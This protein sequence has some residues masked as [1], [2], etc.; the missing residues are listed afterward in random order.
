MKTVILISILAFIFGSAYSQ[1]GSQNQTIAVEFKVLGE[2]GMCKTR[3]EKAAKLE[4]VTSAV[5]DQ[6]TK[7]LKVKYR[8]SIVKVEAI[9]KSIAKAGHDTEKE[10]ADDA[11][12]NKLP[13]C[14]KYERNLN[15]QGHNLPACC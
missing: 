11:V 1:T 5:W 12:Y 3:I 10:K 2:C 9:H 7:M 6:K 13:A 14:C 4:G 8:P 15:H